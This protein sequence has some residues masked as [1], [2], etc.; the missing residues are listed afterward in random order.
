[1]HPQAI[2]TN[3]E[4]SLKDIE[5]MGFDYDYTLATYTPALHQ[6]L[7]NLGKETL[8]E[9]LKVSISNYLILGI[10]VSSRHS[11]L[12]LRDLA[13]FVLIQCSVCIVTDRTQ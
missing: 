11:R 12:A 5:V 7:F 3:N 1:M 2:Y 4:L 6:L 13:P 10:H 8:V 9:H